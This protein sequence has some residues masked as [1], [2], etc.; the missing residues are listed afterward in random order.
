M[1]VKNIVIAVCFIFSV[2]LMAMNTDEQIEMMCDSRQAQ[3]RCLNC[4]KDVNVDQVLKLQCNHS[5]C[6]DCLLSQVK[7]AIRRKSIKQLRCLIRGCK[8]KFLIAEIELIEN[9]GQQDTLDLD[10]SVEDGEVAPDCVHI[11]AF[12]SGIETNPTPQTCPQC[13]FM[14]CKNCG[15]AWQNHILHKRVLPCQSQAV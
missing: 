10:S 3:V 7:F 12:H 5:F 9:R 11:A 1:F 6:Y 15:V 8:H 2:P 4:K 13:H 14:F